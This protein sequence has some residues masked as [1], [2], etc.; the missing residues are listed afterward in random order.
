MAERLDKIHIRNL[1]CRCI[2]GI[3]DDEREKK[4]DVV[5]NLTLE[6]DLSKSCVSDVI[7][8]TVDYKRVK[9]NILALVED[10][11]FFL[12]ERLVQRIADTCLE[13][14]RV[15][16]VCV[17]LDKPGALRFAESV[18]VEIYRTRDGQ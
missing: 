13:D 16:A 9:Q 12:V 8:D 1:K 2:V 18:A 7:G 4:Q 11:Q 5:I 17:S 3:N 14:D 10:S 15:Q 6:A